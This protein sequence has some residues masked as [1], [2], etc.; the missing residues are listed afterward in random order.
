MSEVVKLSTKKSA[1]GTYGVCV[2]V[3]T[4]HWPSSILDL[5]SRDVEVVYPSIN[6]TETARREINRATGLRHPG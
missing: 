3:V 4:Y 1:E 2:G 5:R 6:D